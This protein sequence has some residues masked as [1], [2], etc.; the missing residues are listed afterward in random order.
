M[1]PINSNQ[2]FKSKKGFLP[3]PVDILSMVLLGLVLV[4]S[5]FY[6]TSNFSL[7]DNQYNL[8]LDEV[9]LFRNSPNIINLA[10]DVSF[11]N[12]I[13]NRAIRAVC[14]DIVP[15][16]LKEVYFLEK[17]CTR[18]NFYTLVQNDVNSHLR[19][20]FQNDPYLQRYMATI[21]GKIGICY[22]FTRVT[23]ENHINGY[24]SMGSSVIPIPASRDRPNQIGHITLCSTTPSHESGI[25]LEFP[26]Y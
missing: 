20:R 21:Q 19:N 26:T 10:Y 5:Y 25:G 6:Y 23:D 15:K 13:S 4:I 22:Q 2:I 8:E 1:I 11:D 7:T 24:L 14:R 16:N 17:H 12:E 3:T 18:S 9:E